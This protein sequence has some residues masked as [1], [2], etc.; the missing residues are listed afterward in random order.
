MPPTPQSTTLEVPA[1]ILL[2]SFSTGSADELHEMVRAGRSG[3]P[4]AVSAILDRVRRAAP[5]VWPEIT[6]AI[7]VPVPGHVPGPAH[8]LLLAISEELAAARGWRR[9]TDALLRRSPG[10]EAK[11]G[12]GRDPEAEAA[13]LEW[14]RPTPRAAIVLIDDVVRTGATL[15]ACAEAIR[16]AGDERAVLAVVLAVAVRGEPGG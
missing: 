14:R 12:G 10:P 15:R 1:R 13:T 7:V 4:E 3:K 11:A 5:L 6:A 9:A 16:G 2:G 8:P